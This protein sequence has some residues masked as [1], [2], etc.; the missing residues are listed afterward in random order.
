M[1]ETKHNIKISQD[2]N[3]KRSPWVWGRQFYQSYLKV[4]DAFWPSY[5]MTDQRITVAFDLCV[6]CSIFRKNPDLF[7]N[8]QNELRAHVRHVKCWKSSSD[9]TS[10][11]TGKTYAKYFE[12]WS[13]ILTMSF[14]DWIKCKM[15][16]PIYINFSLS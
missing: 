4:I 2:L 10:Y 3:I 14:T 5:S 13:V 7:V 11:V 16:C 1:M 6:L 15:C 9:F 8:I 12:L